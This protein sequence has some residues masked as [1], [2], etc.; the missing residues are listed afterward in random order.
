MS[1]EPVDRLTKD[2]EGARAL[3]IAAAL[4]AHQSRHDGE[5]LGAVL[6][7]IPDRRA[8]ENVLLAALGLA[9]YNMRVNG[10]RLN[11]ESLGRLIARMLGEE[12]DEPG[13][14]PQNPPDGGWAPVFDLRNHGQPWNAHKV[15]ED[16]VNLTVTHP[17]RGAVALSLT[18]EQAHRLAREIAAAAQAQN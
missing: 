18:V 17:D 7:E 5:A 6:S 1:D 10:V 4:F 11:E 15:G 8:V 13:G 16:S 12:E 2:P 3:R 14:E 9:E